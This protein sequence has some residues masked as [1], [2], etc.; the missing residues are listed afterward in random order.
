M[1]GL[2]GIFPQSNDCEEFW[3]NLEKGKELISEVPLSRWDWKAISGK[4]DNRHRITN[5]HWGGFIDDFDTFD[6]EFFGISATEAKLMDP[7]QRK[8]LEST[9]KALENS[10]IKASDL[11]G[12]RVGVFTGIGTFDYMQITTLHKQFIHAYAATGN[13]HCMSAN[14]VSFFLDFKGPSESVDT[15]CSSSLV[16]LHRACRSMRD[17]E[18]D[19]AIVSGAN[20]LLSESVY[21]T[22]SN[23]NMLSHNGH[24]KTF[25]NNADGY[26]RG[27]GVGVVVLMHMDTALHNQHS[28]IATLKGTAVNHGG[29]T[30]SLT[31]PN[32]QSQ[33]DCIRSAL[34]DAR[35]EATDMNYIEAHGTATNLGDPVEIEGL[36]SVFDIDSHNNK[37]HYGNYKCNI[38]SV[39]TNIGH[40]EAAAGI[41]GL[42]KVLLAIKNRRIPAHI[43][44]SELNENIHLNDTPFQIPNETLD[45]NPTDRY[46]KPVPRTAG[47]S[48]FGFGGVNAHAIVQEFNNENTP[49]QSKD[50]GLSA[51]YLFPISAKTEEALLEYLDLYTKFFEQYAA[52]LH[53][54][55]IQYTLTLGREQFSNRLAIV[56]TSIDDLD[57]KLQRCRDNL[58]LACQSDSGYIFRNHITSG[59]LVSPPDLD[60]GLTIN[61]VADKTNGEALVDTAK[62]WVAGKYIDWSTKDHIT[63]LGKRVPL[64]TYPFARTSHWISTNK[65]AQTAISN[66]LDDDYFE[67]IWLNKPIIQEI[68][69]ES[70]SRVILLLPDHNQFYKEIARAANKQNIP[71]Y[72][73]NYNGSLQGATHLFSPRSVDDA[74]FAENLSSALDS[75]AEKHPSLDISIVDLTCLSQE[76]T[77]IDH[78]ESIMDA[79]RAST[80][81]TLEILKR[82]AKRK[83]RSNDKLSIV[84][85]HAHCLTDEAIN[86]QHSVLWGL[87]KTAFL[88]LPTH[89]DR[90]IDISK[91]DPEAMGQ[92]IL[93]ELLSNSREFEIILRS[94]GRYVP[95]LSPVTITAK[96][97][98]IIESSATYLV[99]G[100]LGALGLEIA[101]WLAT[102]K[103]GRILL[104]S[105]RGIDPNDT[106]ES[107]RLKNKKINKILASGSEVVILTSDV[108]DFDQLMKA[109]SPYV[110]SG[111]LRGI[112][113]LAGSYSNQLIENMSQKD[114][115]NVIGAK[116]RGTL[117]LHKL[118]KLAPLDHFVLFSSAASVW[119]AATG[120]HYSAGNYFLD[121]YAEYANSQSLPV[122]SINWGGLWEDSGIIP[123]THLKSFKS[124][125]IGTISRATGI[126]QLEKLL[127]SGRH[128]TV[129]APVDWNTFV[130][131]MNAHRPHL[132]LSTIKT[133]E[134]DSENQRPK[135]DL[136]ST[137]S[138][139][140]PDDRFNISLQQLESIFR[141][142][143]SIPSKS[144]LSTDR[145]FYEMGLDSLTNIDLKN[146][147]KSK[148]N[149][150]ITTTS[151]FDY[152]TLSSLAEYIVKKYTTSPS[153]NNKTNNNANELSSKSLAAS[154]INT[155]TVL[156]PF[157]QVA[158]T[159]PHDFHHIEEQLDQMNPTE[160]RKA[161]ENELKALHDT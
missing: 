99:T 135:I 134:P 30:T 123:E 70:T 73:T 43:N 64:P 21:I 144:T 106:S 102:R 120:A 155:S 133:P 36:R 95:R 111:Q 140:P 94:G 58:D 157:D 12:K 67:V 89:F 71:C 28:I 92:A 14:R 117:N 42:I 97:T 46:G 55:D 82:L 121:A 2:S 60:S 53:P 86:L 91:T 39:K 22:L 7:M 25:D 56:Y 4:P 27:E 47:I 139:A 77:S 159:L 122:T 103:A 161:L 50:T 105:R 13:V 51:L 119:G 130:P 45:W 150:E 24:C 138:E 32:P 147:L 15:A 125:G 108:C 68:D 26:V 20:A 44:L 115:D 143:L 3:T 132:L 128:K 78:I 98:N 29:R 1:I 109:C 9:W 160:L 17:G 34:I 90:I 114:F 76:S 61:A 85:R 141:E 52:S 88:E 10:G 83:S 81:L 6:S 8:L 118:A 136:P 145:G 93:N 158:D 104:L 74:C 112:F 11:A 127:E 126:A 41:S 124:I 5:I 57:K 62:S 113:H 87:C 148:L 101:D 156:P 38:G 63:T 149:V 110:T 18:C 153:A 96:Q 151:L 107:T 65:D 48:S 35:L 100:G 131:L 66:R 23:A 40:L 72:L 152:N 49:P 69:T 37:Q 19:I 80:G 54:A 154:N 146:K 116:S 84:C 75:I 137:L 79:I 129:V 33:A 59:S 31:A 142:T 16:A